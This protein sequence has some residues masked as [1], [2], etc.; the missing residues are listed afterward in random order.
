MKTSRSELEQIKAQL[1]E[2]LQWVEAKIQDEPAETP[3]PT[4]APPPK[5]PLPPS[6][7]P[8]PKR[9]GSPP[10][11]TLSDEPIAGMAGHERSGCIAAA[12]IFSAIVV[13]ALFF[14]PSCIY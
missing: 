6:V 9:S 2:L 5:E 8:P 11:P 1:E 13:F 12:I 7:V 14:L 4:P 3:P 10:D